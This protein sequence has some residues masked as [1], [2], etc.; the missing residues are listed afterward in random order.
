MKDLEG[1]TLKDCRPQEEEDGNLFEKE[2]DRLEKSPG[3]RPVSVPISKDAVNEFKA[4]GRLKGQYV[5]DVI[6][7]HPTAVRP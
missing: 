4:L 6:P 5:W 3:A 1:H 7:S 2:L